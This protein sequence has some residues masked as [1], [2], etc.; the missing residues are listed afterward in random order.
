M[1][2]VLSADSWGTHFTQNGIP[3]YFL[4]G[5]QKH[6]NEVLTTFI[7]SRF[8]PPRLRVSRTVVILNHVRDENTLVLVGHVSPGIWEMAK[9]FLA[10]WIVE[11][12]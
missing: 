8:F 10:G 3:F 12:E 7:F 1:D 4:Q 5:L 11:E 6:Y 9:T 2:I